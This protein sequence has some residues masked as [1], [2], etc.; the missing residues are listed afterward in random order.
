MA[1]MVNVQMKTAAHS[2]TVG[3]KRSASMDLET[4]LELSTLLDR[5]V[6]TLGLIAPLVQLSESQ[7]DSERSRT[8]ELIKSA[9]LRGDEARKTAVVRWA[10]VF[11][12][13]AREEME[14]ESEKLK[15]GVILVQNA[16]SGRP[17]STPNEGDKLQNLRPSMELRLL[18]GPEEGES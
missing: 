16:S 5:V 15:E 3:C 18:A 2:E 17:K 9:S 10:T 4:W 7:D 11:G 13:A 1:S 12:R 14:R 6:D 8:L